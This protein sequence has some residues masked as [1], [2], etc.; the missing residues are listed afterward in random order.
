M[1]QEQAQALYRN[2]LERIAMD[3]KIKRWFEKTDFAL[4]FDCYNYWDSGIFY[5][6][7][8]SLN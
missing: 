7:L 6:S 3:R 4:T 5:M 8:V 2:K 1:I